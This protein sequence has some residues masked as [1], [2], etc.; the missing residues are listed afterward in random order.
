[1]Q[2]KIWDKINHPF[3]NFNGEF[4]GV[5][6]CNVIPRFTRHLITYPCW[7]L[8]WSMLVKGAPG[9]YQDLRTAWTDLAIDEL[10][11]YRIHHCSKCIH[12]LI[13]TNAGFA[14]RQSI[15]LEKYAKQ[16]NIEKYDE[17]LSECCSQKKTLFMESLLFVIYHIYQVIGI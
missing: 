2:Y 13:D 4:V 6:I 12:I 9:D 3:P 11:Y 15:Y 7:D 16:H 14:V 5:S 8:S 17:L 1:M 10:W